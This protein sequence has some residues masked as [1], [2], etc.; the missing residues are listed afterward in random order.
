MEISAKINDAGDKVSYNLDSDVY[1][2]KMM[3]FCLKNKGKEVIIKYEAVKD[4]KSL[5]QLR[6][7]FGVILPA[8]VECTGDTDKAMFDGFLRDKYLSSI[9]EINGEQFKYIPTLQINKNKVNKVSMTKFIEDC[10]NELVD[11]GGSIDQ[12]IVDEYRNNIAGLK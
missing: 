7:Y 5:Q 3:G 9:H 10:L 1:L 8:F 11:K 12:S 6:F 2:K 4:V